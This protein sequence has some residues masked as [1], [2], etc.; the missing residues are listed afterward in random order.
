MSPESLAAGA[1]VAGVF[2]TILGGLA[3]LIWNA[4]RHS[5][6]LDAAENHISALQEGAHEASRLDVALQVLS[7]G[8]DT[9]KEQLGELRHDV[10]N[11]LTGRI[12][13]AS[14]RRTSDD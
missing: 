9:V 8:L 3:V 2:V 14:R 1:A 5:Q 11:L 12:T 7:G 13:P 10:R 6:R 4:G